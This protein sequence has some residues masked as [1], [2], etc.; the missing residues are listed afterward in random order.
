MG[1]IFLGAGETTVAKF[2]SWRPDVVIN[3]VV[4]AEYLRMDDNLARVQ[5]F[6]D[7]LARPVINPPQAAA[8]CTR[9]LNPANLAG[10]D[11]LVLPKVSRYQ[12]DLARI[13]E[14][15]RTIE[16]DIAY[17]M[18]VRT[19]FEQESR[20]MTLVH[21]REDLEEGIRSLQS[22]QFYVIEYLG[23]PREHGCFRRIR[24]AFV[25]GQPIIIRADYAHD[26]I[27]RSR[28]IISL[29]IYHDHPDLV[30]KAD[31]IIREPQAELGGKAMSALET[32]GRRLP[33]D[34][35][36][37]DFDVDDEGNVVFFEANASMGMMTPA[38]DP[39]PYPPEATQRLT[40]ALD[41]LLHR[42]AGMKGAASRG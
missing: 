35:F 1:A 18:I 25:S 8:R 40:G 20:N 36:G 13:G 33:L 34:I 38:P 10:I 32:A 29:Q 19:P 3:N 24:S 17:P 15:I 9:Q 16:S 30:E 7:R 42:F 2:R 39:F 37:M 31:A 26:W 28:F 27:V 41:E 4:N 11:G 6:A 23:Q 22:S 5:M 12:R 14:L 21:T